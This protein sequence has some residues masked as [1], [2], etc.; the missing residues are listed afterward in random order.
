MLLRRVNLKAGLFWGVVSLAGI[1]PAMANPISSDEIPEHVLTE[2]DKRAMPLGD[3][4]RIIATAAEELIA[5]GVFAEAEFNNVKIGFCD[6]RR[7]QGPVA[8]TSCARDTILLDSGYAAKDQSL[9][10]KATLAHEMKH[11]F[12]HREQKAAFGES[13]C[14]SDRYIEDK[15]WMEEEADKF[16]DEVAALLFLGRPV[17]IENECATPVSVYLEAD[18]PKSVKNEPRGFLEAP[19]QSTV[20]SPERSLSR[21][22]RLYAESAL[23]GD[24]KQ[25]WRGSAMA[26]KII[27]DGRVLE[28]SRITLSNPFRSTGPFLMRLSCTPELIAE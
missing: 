24:Q 19:P 11:Y 10:L 8:T 2:C 28:L 22:F 9:V 6:L 12:Q 15:I 7:V 25:V 23:E 4:S 18:R 14:A 21:S 13:Y 5:M 1:C 17:E 26:H 3:S 27:L 16:G 20:E